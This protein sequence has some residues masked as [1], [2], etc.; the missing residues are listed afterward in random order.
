MGKALRFGVAR[1]IQR[2]NIESRAKKHLGEDAKYFKPAPRAIGPLTKLGP[3]QY[4]HLEGGGFKSIKQK[5]LEAIQSRNQ[6]LLESD[7]SRPQIESSSQKSFRDRV[8]AIAK[9]FSE[10][11]RDDELI[12]ESLPRLPAIKTS[13]LMNTRENHTP[14]LGDKDK[15][16]ETNK[17][18]ET[19]KKT[20]RP[21]PKSTNLDL[22]DPTHIWVTDNVPPGR[23]DLNNLQEIMLNK[24]S[25]TNYWT[26]EKISERYNIKAE[27]AEKLTKYLS[28]V[29][30]VLSPRMAKC[31][32]YTARTDPVY[33]ATKDII[34]FVDKSLR[35]EL[36]KKYDAM[37]LPTDELDPEIRDLIGHNE[38]QHK[39]IDERHT[40]GHFKHVPLRLAQG[41]TKPDKIGSINQPERITTDRQVQ[42]KLLS[43]GVKP[44]TP[45]LSSPDT[46]PTTSSPDESKHKKT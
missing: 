7:Q 42:E 36:D 23:L 33:Q 35:T 27:Y 6:R 45:R 9:S 39:V 10:T 14:S 2:F 43:S 21:L 16:D 3:S 18:I 34:Y 41:Q 25:D 15:A 30:V 38:I 40:I 17:Q 37:Y 28:Q 26:P 11:R 8:N 31:L 13:L 24:L 4:A 22:R 20:H 12:I 29:R 46:Q 19:A 1:P 32:D 5:R 44:Q